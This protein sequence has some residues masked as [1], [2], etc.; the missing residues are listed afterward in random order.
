MESKDE[1]RRKL[2]TKLIEA[3]SN[4]TAPWQRPWSGIPRQLPHNPIT[5]KPYRG[6]N[7]LWLSMQD[8]P[9]SRWM[10]YKQA[11]ENGWQVRKGEKGTLIEYWKV[12]EDRKIEKEDSSTIT[13]VPLERPQ[14]FRAVVFNAA[15]IDNIP[16]VKDTSNGWKPEQAAEELLKRSG[17]F[18]RHDQSHR[19]FYRPASDSIHLPQRHQ[20]HSAHGYYATAIHELG[21]WTG[22]QTRLKRDLSGSYGS[23]NY[24]K[25]E[26]RAELAAYF[27]CTS[28]GLPNN[29]EHHASYVDSWCRLLQYDPNEIFRAARDASKIQDF[30]DV[31]TPA[32]EPP[33][34]KRAVQHCT[35]FSADLA[36]LGQRAGTESMPSV[37]R[38]GSLSSSPI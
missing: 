27:V 12:F 20:F 5:G 36:L 31:L 19:A 25:E 18:I 7:S 29:V 3:I 1:F 17:A 32:V 37:N 16:P 24:A 33:V 2:T 30:L 8:F 10:T 28:L 23:E 13:R 9:D 14:V 38:I 4:G 34:T 26:L 11:S 15:Q 6:A 35:D 21:H 22:H